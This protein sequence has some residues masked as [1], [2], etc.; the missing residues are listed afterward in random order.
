LRVITIVAT[1]EFRGVALSSDGVNQ[2]LG[3]SVIARNAAR[4]KTEECAANGFALVDT[5][6]LSLAH[7]AF[8]LMNGAWIGRNVD[9]LTSI[10]TLARPNIAKVSS[11]TPRVGPY[12]A[13][14]AL[15]FPL[16]FADWLREEKFTT[17]LV[18]WLGVCCYSIV[19]DNFNRNTVPPAI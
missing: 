15:C 13:D 11:R 12:T 16:E 6:A 8:C 18:D 1:G 2:R 9:L 19:E 17:A 4:G 7:F 10:N 3:E 14:F 5:H